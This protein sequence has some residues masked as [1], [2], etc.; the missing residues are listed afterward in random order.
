M[1]KLFWQVPEESSATHTAFM[2]PV[3]DPVGEPDEHG[4]I[5]CASVLDSGLQHFNALGSVVDYNHMYEKTRDPRWILSKA[6]PFLIDEVPHLLI[7]VPNDHEFIE[8][9]R[10]LGTDSFRFGIA[11]HARHNPIEPGVITEMWIHMVSVC[12]VAAVAEGSEIEERNA[13]KNA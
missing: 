11:G 7:R 5:I 2:G 4:D 10:A 13:R 9:V 1:K 6:E 12:P 3:H 8:K